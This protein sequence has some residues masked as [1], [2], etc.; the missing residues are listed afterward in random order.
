MQPEVTAAA[1]RI[2]L[3]GGAVLSAR[4]AMRLSVRTVDSHPQA[5][6]DMV[7]AVTADLCRGPNVTL[8]ANH[9]KVARG[10]DAKSSQRCLQ[11]MLIF[12]DKLLHVFARTRRYPEH[13]VCFVCRK[14]AYAG[15]VLTKSRM[16]SEA[17]A[18]EV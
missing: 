16:A 18:A 9:F 17:I 6:V 11:D 13:V 4:M 7:A 5:V 12:S 10:V 1:W 15:R 2:A 8:I 3:N 14:S